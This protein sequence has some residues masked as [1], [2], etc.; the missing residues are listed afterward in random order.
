MAGS[1]RHGKTSDRRACVAIRQPALPGCRCQHNSKN[2][3]EVQGIP[4]KR[5]RFR[6]VY[7]RGGGHFFLKRYGISTLFSVVPSWT[8]YSPPLQIEH[9][10][11]SPSLLIA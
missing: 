1:E 5:N 10:P 8:R 2:R 6:L 3:G 4:A 9:P 7:S 11:C